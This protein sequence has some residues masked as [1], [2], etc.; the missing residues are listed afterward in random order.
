MHRPLSMHV[1]IFTFKFLLKSHGI[2]LPYIFHMHKNMVH[3][4]QLCTSIWMCALSQSHTQ[5]NPWTFL[6]IQSKCFFYWR[7]FTSAALFTF[8]PQWTGS[9]F[10]TT[11]VHGSSRRQLDITTWVTFRVKLQACHSTP[12]SVNTDTFESC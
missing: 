7:I 3:L 8:S 4:S 12:A 6:Q 9:T 11:G 10:T 5:K 2:A 1:N